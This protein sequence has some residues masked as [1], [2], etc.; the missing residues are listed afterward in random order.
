MTTESSSR[1]QHIAE[2]FD[3]TKPLAN[4][5]LIHLSDLNATEL[6]FLKEMWT[7]AD[8]TRRHQVVS[9]LVHLNEVDIRLD[10]SSVFV[11]CRHDPDEAIR[12]KAIATLETEENHRLIN[13]L[14]QSLKEDSSPRVRAAAA[15]AL[16][17][18]A[19]LSEQGNLTVHYRDEIYTALL[20]VLDNK[21]ETAEVK[22]RA[23]EAISPF[24]LPRVK[25]LIE[26]AYHT[27]D[28]KLKASS[29]YA[30][31]RNCDPV[32]LT[33]LL[34]ELNNA[35]AEIRYEA[36]SACG[37]LGVEEAVPHLLKLIKDEDDQV[38]EATIKALGEIGGE[39]AKQALNKLAKNPQP[40]IRQAAKSALKELL[41]CEDPL[42]SEL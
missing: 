1:T 32:W 3:S 35:E 38:Q 12:I 27:D 15:I 11:F 22:R 4:S 26:Q 7:K 16:G 39:Q 2:I 23:L 37:E 33:I 13:P 24:N 28:V 40:R 18:F 14:I 31:G 10:F 42:S 17:K 41:F 20:G 19:L 6:K 30:M 5:K 21:T 25:E 29:L 9:Q 8:A 34:A 36:A